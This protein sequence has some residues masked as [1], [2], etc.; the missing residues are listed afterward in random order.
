MS[1]QESMPITLR[2][3]IQRANDGRP[4]NEEHKVALDGYYDLDVWHEIDF[5]PAIRAIRLG[6]DTVIELIDLRH[7]KRGLCL[8]VSINHIVYNTAQWK[9]YSDLLKQRSVDREQFEFR[10]YVRSWAVR[11]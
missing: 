8:S 11:P 6:E 9:P 7:G 1:E 5:I 3:L 2:D 4:Y 10:Y